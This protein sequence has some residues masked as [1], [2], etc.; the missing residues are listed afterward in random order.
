[1]TSSMICSRVLLGFP[2]MVALGL[3]SW[4]WVIKGYGC[5][6]KVNVGAIGLPKMCDNSVSARGIKM[7]DNGF[8]M[9]LHKKQRVTGGFTTYTL[10]LCTSGRQ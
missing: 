10:N 3:I 5:T 9:G 1:M 4:T 7:N 8:E 2:D 6:T